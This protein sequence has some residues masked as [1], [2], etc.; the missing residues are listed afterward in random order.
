LAHCD[1][2]ATAGDADYRVLSSASAGA[3]AYLVEAFLR[4]LREAGYVEGQ[5]LANNLFRFWSRGADT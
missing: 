5:T 1:A 4:G 3:Y 2:G